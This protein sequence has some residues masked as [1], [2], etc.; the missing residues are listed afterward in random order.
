MKNAWRI[1]LFIDPACI[2]PQDRDI[3]KLVS[4]ASQDLIEVCASNGNRA[5]LC[6]E[7]F[8][9]E[10]AAVLCREQARLKTATMN[11]GSK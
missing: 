3:G 6:C 1:L 4:S 7:D 10:T 9:A 11:T 5:G 8:T 2:D